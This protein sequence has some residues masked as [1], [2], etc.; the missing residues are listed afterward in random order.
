MARRSPTNERYQKYTGPKGQTRKSASQARPK[1]SSTGPSSPTG[2]KSSGAKGSSAARVARPESPA[3]KAARRQWWILLGVGLV[4]TAVSWLVR[5]YVHT[6]WATGA[7]AISLGL[8][9]TAIFYALYIDWT[10]LRPERK[11]AIAA[12]KS[13]KNADR[14]DS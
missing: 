14:K 3:Y 2:A 4:L 10:K 11:A 1:R 5:G 12:S 6:S 9:Y 7:S 13:G 8:A